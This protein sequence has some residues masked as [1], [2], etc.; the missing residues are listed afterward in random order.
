MGL[1]VLI[2][3]AAAIGGPNFKIET[4][5]DNDSAIGQLVQLNDQHAVVKL[6]RES[7]ISGPGDDAPELTISDV[8]FITAV[9]KPAAKQAN[10]SA[11]TPPP[12]KSLD[13][14]VILETIDGT[15]LTGFGF[16]AAKGVARLTLDSGETLA[17]PMKCLER[18]EFRPD[19]KPAVWP[20]LPKDAAGDLIVVQKKEATD[21]V[22]GVLGEVTA[23]TVKFSLDGDV[24]PVKRAKVLGLVCFHAS[25][26]DTI[27][28]TK[29]IVEASGDWRVHATH[30]VL[31]NGR[32]RMT[33]TFGATIDRPLDSI[34]K[35]DFS[36][37]RMVYFSDLPLDSSA[38]TPFLG[39]GLDFD[40]P[41]EAL[42]QFYKPRFDH[43]ID[44]GA[45]SIHGKPYRKGV[46]IV[47]HTVLEYKIAGK[48]RQFRATAGIDDSLQ[49]A[50]NVKLTIEG[51]GRTLYSGKIT[52]RDPA[53]ELNLDVSG[54]KRLRIMA[55]FGGGP[56]VGN[57]L[58]LGDARIVK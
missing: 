53:A 37:S 25:Q 32:V 11:A 14:T 1:L 49:G 41:N 48:G 47:P 5:R 50:G 2:A 16:E 33:T 31:V 7:T 19:G 35:I 13:P 18:V 4:F 6:H 24:V 43:T 36:P 46:A 44:G 23:D 12:K 22:E 51:D 10:L 8:R 58:D 17:V 27:Q 40:K 3:M 57:Y 56:D 29:A 39:F 34:L 15:R 9:P 30:V 26:A 54:V 28:E 45:L 42:A 55:D 21:L 38:W 20:E 52:G